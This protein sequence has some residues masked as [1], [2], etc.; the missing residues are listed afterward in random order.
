[1]QFADEVRAALGLGEHLLSGGLCGRPGGAG[2]LEELGDPFVR[3]GLN[4]AGAPVG[5][6]GEGHNVG[7]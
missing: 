5:G 7:S 6:R 4:P 2:F 3:Q 1:M